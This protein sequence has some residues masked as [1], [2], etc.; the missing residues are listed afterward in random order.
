M[1]L[2]KAI[3]HKLNKALLE[4]EKMEFDNYVER[5]THLNGYRL[6]LRELIKLKPET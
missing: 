4:A 3:E 5:Q 1:S 2:F 6:A